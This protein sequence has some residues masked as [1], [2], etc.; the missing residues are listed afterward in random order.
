MFV[1]A[2]TTQFAVTSN[3]PGGQKGAGGPPAG[4]QVNHVGAGADRSLRPVPWNTDD[5]RNYTMGYLTKLSAGTAGQPVQAAWKPPAPA[6]KAELAQ[7]PPQ[8]GSTPV[9]PIRLDGPA[10]DDAAARQAHEAAETKRKAEW[11]A[12]QAKKRAAEQVALDKLAAMS[13]EDVIKASM[14]HIGD[15]TEKITRRNMKEQVAEHIQALCQKDA[16]FARRTMLPGKSMVL[17]FQYITRKAYDYIQDE[18]K[19]NDIKPGPGQEGYGCDIPDDLCFQ[20]ARNYFDAPVEQDKEKFVPRPY[21][22]KSGNES[23]PKKVQKT[24]KEPKP[25]PAPKPKENPG[26]DGQISLMGAAV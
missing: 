5:W 8:I 24:K 25:K 6:P 15:A 1:P 13:D 4:V 23:T 17:C 14:R 26:V 18:M 2:Q 16:A 7:D 11:D 20:W 22:P 9:E 3:S 12:N 21:V 19:A 10:A